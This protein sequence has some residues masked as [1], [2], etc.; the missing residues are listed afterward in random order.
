[1]IQ[2][3]HRRVDGFELVGLENSHLSLAIA[4][5]LGAKLVSLVDRASG[6]EWMW[7]PTPQLR[8]FAKSTG[9]P[10]PE[11]PLVGADEC[12]PTIGPCSWRDLPGHD[13]GEAWTEAWTL[14]RDAIERGELVTRLRL[15]I[16][17]FEISLSKIV[18]FLL[19]HQFLQVIP[20]TIDSLQ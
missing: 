4:P 10:F 19:F 11:G 20:V 18:E 3:T 7:R 17:P 9:T 13:H 15:P 16:F 5:A 1:M 12:I 8:L 6:R 14:D 2:V